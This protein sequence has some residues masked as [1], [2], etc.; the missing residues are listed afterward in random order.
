M[1][2]IPLEERK[3]LQ[4][5]LLVKID[6]IC[7]EKGFRY[8][9]NSGTL[10]G[11]VRHKGY[12][13]WDDDIDI[14]MPRPDYEAFYQHF[15]ETNE[16]SCMQLVSYR[17]KSSIYPFFKMIDPRTT[18]IEHYVNPKYQTGVW[19]DIFPLDGVAKGDDSSFRVNENIKSKYDFI[20]ANPANATTPLRKAVKKII[21]PFFQ[22]KDIYALAKRLDE[23]LATTPINEANDVAMA[24]WGYGP[25]ERTP[26]S[27]LKTC[28]LE[29]EGKF[30]L[31]PKEYD[32]YLSSLFGDYMTPPPIGQRE[33]HFCSA[34]WKNEVD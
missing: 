14:A 15:L 30:F 2:E 11:A 13:P 5:D 24:M 18:V 32:L 23:A 3:S 27:I 22:R 4:L 34:Y 21:A 6:K 16:D 17:D 31:A 9:L 33:A 7:R 29:F 8:Y 28:E 19:V 26:Y 20:I 12:I 1:K 25:C 10:L